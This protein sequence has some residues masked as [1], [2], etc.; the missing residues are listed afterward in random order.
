MRLA[1]VFAV[2][3]GLFIAAPAHADT[4]EEVL[5][6]SRAFDDAQRRQSAEDIERYLAPDFRIIYS[7]GRVG[8]RDAFIAGFTSP[9]MRITELFVE[10]PFT[11]DLGRDGAV[12]GGVGVIRGTESGVPFEE[13]FRFADTFARRDG[14]WLAVYVQVTPLA[15]QAN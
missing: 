7:S 1:Q 13:R 11:I 12:V 15:A 2:V 8:D 5:A 10:E 14:R 3:V 6:A 9:T 4:R